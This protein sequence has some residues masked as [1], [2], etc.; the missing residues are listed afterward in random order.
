MKLTEKQL[1]N[2][3]KSAVTFKELNKQIEERLK[4]NELIVSHEINK[5]Y[6]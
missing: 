1:K 6:Y 4:S 2:E 5:K 3:P